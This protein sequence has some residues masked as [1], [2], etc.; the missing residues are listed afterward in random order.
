MQTTQRKSHAR[1]AKPN[2]GIYPDGRP[3]TQAFGRNAPHESI[4]DRMKVRLAV[5]DLDRER[6]TAQDFLRRIIRE[7]KIRFYLH[8]TNR[9][10]ASHLK[11]FLRWFGGAPHTISREHVRCYLEYLVDAGLDQSTVG[12]HLSAIRT[13]F[14]KLCY[15]EVTLGLATPRKPKRLPIVLSHAE[16]ERLLS[17][18]I[19]VRDKLLLGLMYAT[20]LR[21][22]EVVEL[23]YRDIDF[24]RQ[25]IL[26]RR[27]KGAK[28]RCV[29]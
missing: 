14:D 15:R 5:V 10:Y 3:Y 22:S 27:G 26:V 2:I 21:V 20:G 4:V 28:D 29:P 18:A 24:N 1:P 16:I 8:N 17:T 23:T 7:L 25:Q 9:N 19:R 6:P 12:N 13:A 11:S